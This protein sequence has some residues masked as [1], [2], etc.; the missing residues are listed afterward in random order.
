MPYLR[1]DLVMDDVPRYFGW[2]LLIGKEYFLW[3]PNKQLVMFD[4]ELMIGGSYLDPIPMVLNS[5]TSFCGPCGG[6]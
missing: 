3:S 1:F 6:V 4:N 5:L 2:S